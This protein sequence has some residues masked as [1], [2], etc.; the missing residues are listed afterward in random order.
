MIEIK[1]LLLNFKNI[2]ISE[3]LKKDEIRRIIFEETKINVNS[4]D[5]QLKN[6]TI[7]L[8]IKPI[9]KNE[10]FLKKDKIFSKLKEVLGKRHPKDFR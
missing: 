4:K 8:N 7:F 5:V 1:N 3:S 6:G 10:I 2:L 9:Y